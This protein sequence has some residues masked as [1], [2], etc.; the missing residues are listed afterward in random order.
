MQLCDLHLG[1]YISVTLHAYKA[2]TQGARVFPRR[3]AI[4]QRCLMQLPPYIRPKI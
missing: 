1:S 3:P 4:A 2:E